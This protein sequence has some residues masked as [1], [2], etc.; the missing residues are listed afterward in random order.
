MTREDIIA[1]FDSIA[2]IMQIMGDDPGKVKMY[3]NIAITLSYELPDELHSPFSKYALPKIKG[4]G[5]STMEKIAELVDT[6]KCQY[7]ED[8][9]ASIPSGVLDLLDISGVGPSTAA[10]LYHEVGID[11]L[12]TLQEALDTQK[13]RNVKG[14]GK[15]TEENIRQGLEALLR[16]RQI[17]LTGYVFPVVQSVVDNLRHFVSDISIAGDLRRKT[18]TIREAQIVVTGI[19]AMEFR[20]ALKNTELVREV[21]S[22]WRVVLP[23]SLVMLI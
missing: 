10:K 16:H 2:D 5:T 18:E 21:S 19:N 20:D 7:Y 14:M 11:S 3:R 15:K 12:K 22:E 4:I 6:G 13:L 9:R 8:L 1:V 23:K 17:K